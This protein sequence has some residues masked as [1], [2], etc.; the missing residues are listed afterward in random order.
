MNQQLD[1]IDRLFI[2][3]VKPP[4]KKKYVKESQIFMNK[5]KRK[6]KIPQ[7]LSETLDEI[8]KKK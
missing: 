8:R 2:H 7:S 5:S 3:P 6:I 4:K 1:V